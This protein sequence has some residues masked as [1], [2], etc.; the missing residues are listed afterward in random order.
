MDEV[1]KGVELNVDDDPPAPPAGLVS[2]GKGSKAAQITRKQ[3]VD[4]ARNMCLQRAVNHA[5]SD[6]LRAICNG[7]VNGDAGNSDEHVSK[8]GGSADGR[9]KKKVA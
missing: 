1:A 2:L 6:L 8:D 7:N 3:F 9:T 5:R 4:V